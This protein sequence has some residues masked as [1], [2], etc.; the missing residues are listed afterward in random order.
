M[1]AFSANSSC[2]I[3]RNF[4]NVAIAIPIWINLSRFWKETPLPISSTL[5]H[6]GAE[7]GYRAPKFMELLYVS[8]AF[9]SAWDNKHLTEFVSNIIIP[10]SI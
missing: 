8:V 6:T 5:F 1:P 10:V 9:L 2:D 7:F 3:P 4:R